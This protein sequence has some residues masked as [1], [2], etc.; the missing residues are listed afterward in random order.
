MSGEC[1]IGGTLPGAS[2]IDRL[3][4]LW[5]KAH[6]RIVQQD[7]EIERLKLELHNEKQYAADLI[8]TLRCEAEDKDA[9]IERLKAQ[10]KELSEA[11]QKAIGPIQPADGSLEK[12][13]I[14]ERCAIFW[15]GSGCCPG[16]CEAFDSLRAE[17]DSLIHLRD[18][19]IQ[20]A[21]E[22]TR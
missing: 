19:L 13:A 6:D 5:I 9:E 11:Y 21:R 3:S 20:R 17:N 1:D 22:A 10:V 2:E 15:T 16:I 12:E 7:A 14:E 18:D 4:K 8:T